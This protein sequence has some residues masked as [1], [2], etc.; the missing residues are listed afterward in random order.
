MIQEEL[1]FL[2]GTTFSWDKLVETPDHESKHA[3][4]ACV[5]NDN[6]ETP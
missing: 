5:P 4:E 2:P 1:Q 6:Q 3:R